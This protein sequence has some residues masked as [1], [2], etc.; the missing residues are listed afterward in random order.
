MALSGSMTVKPSFTPTLTGTYEFSLTV[1]DG[2]N[3]SQPD[4]VLIVVDSPANTV[5][6]ADAGL[7][8]T[9]LVGSLVVLD[10][11]RSLDPDGDPLT[12][13]WTP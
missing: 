3:F 5:P 9:V 8:Q 7:D 6:T 11:S 4:T 12:Y 13:L 2:I 1:S 10:G